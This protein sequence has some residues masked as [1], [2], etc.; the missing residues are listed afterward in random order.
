M[1]VR[2]S[3]EVGKDNCRLFGQ[4]KD[5]S[6]QGIA[7][8]NMLINKIEDAHIVEGDSLSADVF[9]KDLLMRHFD[10]VVASPP[11]SKL[12]MGE[13]AHTNP[14]CPPQDY[15]DKWKQLQQSSTGH[16]SCLERL[17]N[18]TKPKEGVLVIL[19]PAELLS[20][21]E[22]DRLFREQLISENILD[23]VISIPKKR[24]FNERDSAVLVLDRSREMG[25][26]HAGKS[27]VMFIDAAKSFE[28]YDAASGIEYRH[29]EQVIATY[30]SRMNRVT[31]SSLVNAE[32]IA[33][34]NFDLSVSRYI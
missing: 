31:F 21:G 1:L 32:E 15:E 19:V 12:A 2:V 29:V 6:V 4:E 18:Q 11:L 17:L 3:Q 34:N 27:G 25:G 22:S 9:G 33:N 30:L 10:R 23:A 13:V 24:M 20:Q 5:S 8:L 16:L 28:N 26:K 7:R 14:A